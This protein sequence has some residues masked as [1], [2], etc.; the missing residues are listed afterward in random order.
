[1]SEH[2]SIIDNSNLE[3]IETHWE[4]YNANKLKDH[5]DSLSVEELRTLVLKQDSKIKAKQEEIETLS[6][7]ASCANWSLSE[8]KMAKKELISSLIESGFWIPI[9]KEFKD[10]GQVYGNEYSVSAVNHIGETP[11]IGTCIED[12]KGISFSVWIDERIPINFWNIYRVKGKQHIMKIPFVKS[13]DGVFKFK[14]F[15][16]AYTGENH[17]FF[18]KPFTSKDK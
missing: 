11:L 9:L 2:W 1:M 17:Y 5:I 4:E 8:P 7:I 18:A 16:P 3:R 13:E 12:G 14:L 10:R 6:H 15:G